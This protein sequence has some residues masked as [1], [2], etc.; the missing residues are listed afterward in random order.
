M[1][2]FFKRPQAVA[3][4]RAKRPQPQKPCAPADMPSRPTTVR[5]IEGPER[6]A[7]EVGRTRL[8]VAGVMFSLA[9]G[10][11]ALRA[12]DLTLLRPGQPASLAHLSA[13]GAAPA[14]IAERRPIT[15]RHGA[16]LATNLPTASLYANAQ[17]VLD[18]KEAAKKLAK[19]LPDQKEADLFE[20][21][22]SGKSF[23]WIKRNLTPT[24]QHQVNA[25]G[26]PGLSFQDEQRRFYPLGALAAHVT[27]Y[28]GVDNRGLSGVEQHFDA[29]LRDMTRSHEPLRLSLDAR[30]QHAVRDELRR[31][32]E[33][34]SALGGGGIVMDVHTGEVLALVSLPDFEPTRAGAADRNA[35]FNRITLGVYELGSTMKTL[36]TAM[37][38]DKGVVGMQGGY[39]ATD[40]I[41]FG[42]FVINDDHP[43]SRWLSVPEIFMYSSNIG[44]VKM[45]QDVGI[46]GQRA[47]LQKF[48]MLTRP[49]LELPEV[50]A[51]LMPR[52]WRQLESM[53]ISFGHGL[54]ASPLQM[55]MAHAATVNGGWMRPATLLPRSAADQQNAVRVL[56]DE[57]SVQ[58]RKLLRLV[59]EQGTARK[60]AAPGYVVG[61]KTGTAE[62][63]QAGGY[64]RNAVLNTFVAAFPMQDPRYVVLGMID[65]PKGTKETFGFRTAGWTIAPAVG[66]I[67]G[68]IAPILGVAPVDENSPELKQAL[69]IEM[70]KDDPAVEGD[71]ASAPVRAAATTAQPA[72]VEFSPA[73]IA[74]LLN[75]Q[76][77]GHASR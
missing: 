56:N 47:Y 52:Q 26:I 72:V 36:T 24:E 1:M 31:A 38:L 18:A 10:L 15:D 25:L 63:A 67:I 41:R 39:D 74:D 58:M 46:E 70:P 53:T 16:V 11:L 32:I 61:G 43:K 3:V 59:V 40:P 34:F 14:T 5:R 71:R 42:R 65:E 13:P 21:L 76:G 7:L 60:A 44:T 20:K 48:G 29:Q 66:R 54:S 27:G 73:R 19:V 23:V 30:V 75:A 28:A 50:G 45:A 35:R 68:R 64:N 69:Y 8:I 62:K 55:A 9:F 37:A 22:S 77:G 2:R 4:G 57:T 17:K 12:L 33:Q 6:Q 49:T 51:P